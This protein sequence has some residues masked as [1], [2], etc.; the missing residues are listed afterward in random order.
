MTHILT[1]PVFFTWIEFMT[2]PIR[3]GPLRC[4]IDHGLDEVRPTYGEDFLS[5]DDSMG[6]L[7]IYLHEWLNLMLN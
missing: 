1:S 7:Y 5:Q 4:G 2:Q 3:T 6:R